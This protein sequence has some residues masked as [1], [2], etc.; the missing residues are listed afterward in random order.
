[1]HSENTCSNCGWAQASVLFEARNVPVHVCVQY[2]TAAEARSC[3][4]GDIR[5]LRCG[6]CGSI[7]NSAFD[8]ALVHYSGCYENSLHCSPAFQQFAHSLALELVERHSLHDAD[9]I[10]IGCGRGEFLELLCGLGPN[11]GVGFDHSRP[12]GPPQANTAVRFVRDFY[13]ESYSSL[14]ARFYVCRHVLEHVPQPWQFL[15]QLRSIIGDRPEVRLYFEVPNAARVLRTMS[16]W[17]MIYEHCSY[18]TTG[19]LARLFA[20]A[21]FDVLSAT[22]CFQGQY[23]GVE[24]AP[25]H[26]ESGAIPFVSTGKPFE[27]ASQAAAFA[28]NHRSFLDDWRTRMARLDGRKV[29]IWGAGAAGVAFLNMIDAGELIEYAVDINPRK[30]GK[31]LP[32]GGKL[33]VPPEFLRSY[34]PDAVIIMNPAY[35]AEIR[36]NAAEIGIKAQFLYGR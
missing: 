4:R 15:R 5:I 8:P 21:G 30:H 20:E 14:P 19:S 13:T 2:D 32:G 18:F 17:D 11:R 16:M 23:V 9:I 1:M 29:V 31:F 24:A 27:I 35:D 34:Q 3:A 7:A 28:A 36:R 25:H 22:E 6:R 26:S 12:Q 10:E 33:V